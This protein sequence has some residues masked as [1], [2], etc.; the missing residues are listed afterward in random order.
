LESTEPLAGTVH[1]LPV[2][3][4]VLQAVEKRDSAFAIRE[5][6]CEERVIHV[7]DVVTGSQCGVD[8]RLKGR[9]TA[10]FGERATRARKLATGIALSK[11]EPRVDKLIAALVGDCLRGDNRFFRLLMTADAGHVV[12]PPCELAEKARKHATVG[13]SIS[14]RQRGSYED[15][16]HLESTP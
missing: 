4:H 2:E 6:A 12:I 8:G 3:V 1:R 15:E 5:R 13:A 16:S 10:V 11:S 7:Q 9:G 14:A